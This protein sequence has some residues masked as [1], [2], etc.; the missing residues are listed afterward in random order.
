METLKLW[1]R[2]APGAVA[3]QDEP[4][5]ETHL[6]PGGAPRGAVVVFP[7]GAYHH[8][9]PHEAGP[10]AAMLNDAGF[11][12][13][14]LRY[15][16][17]HLPEILRIPARSCGCRSWERSCRH[18]PADIVAVNLCLLSESVRS[19]RHTKTRDSEPRYRIRIHEIRTRYERGFLLYCHL[20]Q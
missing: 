4:G 17:A 9:A 10:I 19:V 6:L 15:R 13:F 20:F 18:R 3:G 12:A 8:L 16:L 11:H 14:V 1:E 7:G 5:L 2:G